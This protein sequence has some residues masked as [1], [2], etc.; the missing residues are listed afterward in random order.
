MRAVVTRSLQVRYGNVGQ[1]GGQTIGIA[2]QVRGR[3]TG[4][5]DRFLEAA[6]FELDVNASSRNLP[7]HEAS[8]LNPHGLRDE[9][10]I[11]A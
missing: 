7:T 1:N 5:G 8:A 9:K 11:D 3:F 6:D 2:M 10:V 4:H